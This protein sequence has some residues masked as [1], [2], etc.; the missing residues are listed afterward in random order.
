VQVCRSQIIDS[1][2]T[3]LRIPLRAVCGVTTPLVKQGESELLASNSNVKNRKAVIDDLMI[4]RMGPNLPW[5]AGKSRQTGGDRSLLRP[6]SITAKRK[7]AFPG[8]ATLQP[9]KSTECMMY[10]CS[11]PSPEVPEV[12]EVGHGSHQGNER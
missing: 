3:A 8:R 9:R 6:C 11:E 1:V 5:P 7:R 12:P 10:R 4:F 2:L